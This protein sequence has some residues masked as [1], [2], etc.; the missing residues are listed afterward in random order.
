MTGGLFELAVVILIAAVFG[1]VAKLLRQPIILA[2]LATGIC[3]GYFGFLPIQNG[4]MFSVFSDLGIM[5]LLFLVGL[6]IN[7]TSLRLVGKTSL[8]VGLGQVIFTT[9]LGYIIAVGL[10]F[11]PLHAL[12]IGVALM[13]SSTVVVIKLLSDKGD[14][15]SLYGKISIGTLLVQDIV[16]I[17]ILVVLAGIQGAGGAIVWGSLILT[18][19]KGI[20]LFVAIVWLGR[21]FFPPLF[22]RI[23]HSQELLFLTSLAWL[24]LLAAI[25]SKIGFSVE[26]A[27]F[28]AGL[29][30]ANSS[31]HFE[32]SH[33]IRS[34]RDFFILIFFVILGF[35]A[36]ISN[37]S[38][39]AIPLIVFSLFVLIGNPLIVL[40]IMG[41]MGHRRRTGFL[42]GVSLAQ[43]SEFS[44]VLAA[45]GLKLG[46]IN[47][48]VITLI[49]SV[50]IITIALSTYLI[51]Y[52][53]SIYRVCKRVL[54]IFEKK[55]IKELEYSERGSEKSIILI[56]CHRTGES[57]ALG[58]P[59][60]DL[61]IIDFDP[62]VIKKLKAKGYEV[63]YGD[64]SDDE[65]LYNARIEDAK[66]IIS[67]SPALEDNIMLM[68][69]IRSFSKKPKIVLR[70]D[71][72]KEAKILYAHGADYVLLPNFTAG[73]YLGKTIA[74]SPQ[75]EILSHLKENDLALMRRLDV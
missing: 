41:L 15:N 3:I 37:F 30:L 38:G 49:T 51:M 64:S 46:H 50:G 70:A 56:G 35:S 8:V 75:M 54:K 66:L 62:D 12:Y 69:K 52:G 65:V 71:T 21:K 40:I 10:G 11:I 20:L 6:E 26:I 9:L 34:L 72:E 28:L 55:Q 14:L 2:Y 18:L 13:F 68:K 43:V 45:L 39:L 29:A 24:F 42:T 22:D 32:I 47:D 44:L 1:I 67:T 74:L 53:D 58:L 63:I 31:E 73:Q 25:V 61:L 5:F 27:G 19:L 36:V 60:K 23:A 16:A 48:Q 4:E 57:L 33:R 17:M 59:R 7:Y